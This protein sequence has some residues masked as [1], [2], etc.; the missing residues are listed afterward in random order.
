MQKRQQKEKTNVAALR[1]IFQTIYQINS[2]FEFVNEFSA[3]WR[4]IRNSISYMGY[5]KYLDSRSIRIPLVGE[6]LTMEPENALHK[7]AIALMK[8]SSV[9]SHLM[10]G[11]TSKLEEAIFNFL[12]SYWVNW[13]TAAVTGKSVNKKYAM[14]I[15]ISS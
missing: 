7:S 14:G 1:T 13:C 5:H 15:Q 10:K 9:V 12:H 6:K 2:A 3:A 8:N 4:R 11:E